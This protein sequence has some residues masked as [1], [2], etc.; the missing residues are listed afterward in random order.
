QASRTGTARGL[1]WVRDGIARRVIEGSGSHGGFSR[2]MT[3]SPAFRSNWRP[4]RKDHRV[5]RP[6]ACRIASQSAQWK[7]HAAYSAT[8]AIAFLPQRAAHAKVFRYE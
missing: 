1:R 3:A 8:Q 6:R 2:M 4:H 7:N 5:R